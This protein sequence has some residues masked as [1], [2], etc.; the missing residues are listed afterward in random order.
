MNAT[1]KAYRVL[2]ACIATTAALVATSTPSFG[3]TGRNDDGSWNRSSERQSDRGGRSEGKQSKES[4]FKE[5]HGGITKV[6]TT[7]KGTETRTLN[8]DGSVD[9]GYQSNENRHAAQVSEVQRNGGESISR[10]R[11][12]REAREIREQQREQA[13]RGRREHSSR[14]EL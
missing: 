2:F 8:Q 13:E 10:E 12:E 11:A 7:S 1:T 6:E 9:K 3:M 4:F 5:S 14:G